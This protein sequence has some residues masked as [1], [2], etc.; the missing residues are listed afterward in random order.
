MVWNDQVLVKEF[1]LRL[2][3][4]MLIVVVIEESVVGIKRITR[5]M[6]AVVILEMNE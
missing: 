3:I 1:R 6:K 4:T 5:R 2:T